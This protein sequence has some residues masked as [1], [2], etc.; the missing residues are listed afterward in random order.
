MWPANQVHKLLLPAF[1]PDGKMQ[2]AEHGTARHI[3]GTTGRGRAG[4]STAQH[5]TARHSTAQ[6][7]TAPVVPVDVPQLELDLWSRQVLSVHDEEECRQQRDDD[8]EQQ[9]HVSHLNLH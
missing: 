8:P 5:G 6:Y 4:H 1:K 2:V 9:I 7:N 3:K